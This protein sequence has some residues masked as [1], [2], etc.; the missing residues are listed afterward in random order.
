MY[1][2]IQK[3]IQQLFFFGQFSVLFLVFLF[4]ILLRFNFTYLLRV[5][6]EFELL[7]FSSS[8]DV[9]EGGGVFSFFPF[10]SLALSFLVFTFLSF[11]FF[12]SFVL[13]DFL[14][15]SSDD[16]EEDLELDLDTGMAFLCFFSLL[17]WCL[18]YFSFLN[19][20]LSFSTDESSSDSD[21]TS[22]LAH[23]LSCSSH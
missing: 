6:S 12:L 16:S 8:E 4:Y 7:S 9:S 18:S 20:L 2:P 11:S 22:A 5:K 23:F 14:V 19:F 3:L 15:S 13:S 10:F 17:W 1:L 21:T